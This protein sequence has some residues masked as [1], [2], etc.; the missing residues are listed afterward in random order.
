[1]SVLFIVKFTY[2]ILIFDTGALT[3]INTRTSITAKIKYLGQPIFSSQN[4]F[5]DWL[6]S[7]LRQSEILIILPKSN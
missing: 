1:M 4:F 6:W 5:T 7:Y 3:W 2:K